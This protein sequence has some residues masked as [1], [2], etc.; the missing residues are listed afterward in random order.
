MQ[1]WEMTTKTRGAAACKKET[2]SGWRE[3]NKRNGGRGAVPV[4]LLLCYLLYN[5]KMAALAGRADFELGRQGWLKMR[6]AARARRAVLVIRR[7]EAVTRAQAL[8]SERCGE[9]FEDVRAALSTRKRGR[10]ALERSKRCPNCRK[11]R[12]TSENAREGL[13]SALGGMRKRRNHRRVYE[14]PENAREGLDQASGR[15]GSTEIAERYAKRPKMPVR[16]LIRPWV[17]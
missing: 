1:K 7:R 2:L 9:C 15:W 17:G 11:A 6:A 8:R 3:V 4:L 14:T 13:D 12:E 16:G 10:F 5:N